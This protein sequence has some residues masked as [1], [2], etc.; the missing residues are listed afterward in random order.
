MAFLTINGIF[1]KIEVNPIFWCSRSRINQACLQEQNKCVKYNIGK[2]IQ[3]TF[4]PSIMYQLSGTFSPKAPKK[5]FNIGTLQ[6]N[7][8]GTKN[9]STILSPP[10]LDT[11]CC[12]SRSLSRRNWSVLCSNKCLCSAHIRQHI[13]CRIYRP[14]DYV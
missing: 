3:L 14:N 6:H 2:K 4:F 8:L 13:S 12:M 7:Y 9:A 11:W 1:K 10:R 5:L